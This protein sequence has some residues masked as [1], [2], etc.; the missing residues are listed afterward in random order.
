MRC[1]YCKRNLVAD[2][3]DVRQP[4]KEHI[5]QWAI[6]SSNLLVTYDVCSCCNSNL[7]ET[8]DADFINQQ[9]V[10]LQRLLFDVKG[11]SGSV[12]PVTVKG[13]ESEKGIEGTIVFTKDAVTPRHVPKVTRATTQDGKKRSVC[14]GSERTCKR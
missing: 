3:I 5:V 9:V 6:G 14:L 1:I 4:S 10:G 8:V 2:A 13:E 12:P 11:Y 7:G